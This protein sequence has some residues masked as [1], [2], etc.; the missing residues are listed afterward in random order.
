[1]PIRWSPKAADDL[2]RIVAH[3]Q[4]DSR[5]AAQRVAQTVFARAEALNT[6]PQLGR[7]GRVQGTRELPLSP[8]PFFIVYRIRQEIIEIAN[9]LHGAQ[10]WP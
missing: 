4:K 1:M 2:A 5:D 6:F 10:R 7:P 9:I 8:L 3:I